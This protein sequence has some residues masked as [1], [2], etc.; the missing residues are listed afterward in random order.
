MNE[1]TPSA[2]RMRI[3]GLFTGPVLLVAV[4]LLPV[5]QGWSPGAWHV[6][7][8]VALMV[9]WWISEAIPVY[10]TGLVPLVLFPMLDIADIKATAAPYADPLIFLFL[11]GFMIA[12]AIQR[13]GLHRRMALK[14]LSLTG[15]SPRALVGGFMGA[16]AFLSMWISNTATAVMMLPIAVSVILLM[17]A[18]DPEPESEQR[19]E[20]ALLLAIAWSCSIGGVATLIGTPPNAMLAAY[21]EREYD[22]SISFAGWMAFALP[23]SLFLLLLAWWLLCAMFKL[24]STII[25]GVTSVINAQRLELGPMNRGERLAL[26]GFVLAALL[27]IFRAPLTQWLPWLQLSDA[28][29]A[30][31]VSLILFAVPVDARRGINVLNWDDARKLPW[32]VLLLFGGGLSLASALDNTGL[33][34]HLGNYL[35]QAAAMP[36]WVIVAICV[37]VVVFVTEVMSNT[38]ATAAFI[39]VVATVAVGV[40]ESPL[41][42]AVPAALAASC[43]FMLPAATPPNAVVFGSGRLTIQDMARAGILF[44]LVAIIVI[45]TVAVTP[46][47]S[48]FIG[49]W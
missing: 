15:T 7:G 31:G 47:F 9:C 28:G 2:S 14:L 12:Q 18:T 4:L 24:P 42:L 19:F 8:C 33:A 49:G 41:A 3:A 45:S 26:A 25:R 17:E 5:P 1:L 40:G 39:P 29:I 34:A 23:L 44:N 38:A 11:G 43:A 22:I 20:R 21:L 27:W 35:T 36:W 30:I 46:L 13:W 37:F 16:C 6:L 48:R 10:A 32:G